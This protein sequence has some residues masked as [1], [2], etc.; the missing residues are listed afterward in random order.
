MI[1]SSRCILSDQGV[2]RRAASSGQSRRAVPRSLPRRTNNSVGRKKAKAKDNSARML[3]GPNR[4]VYRRARP[5]F[6]M[7]LSR[8]TP[9]TE[10]KRTTATA[11]A[12]PLSAESERLA[13]S[14]VKTLEFESALV[15]LSRETEITSSPRSRKKTATAAPALFPSLSFSLPLFLES[16]VS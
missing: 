7:K 11:N 4:S 2:D 16:E 10:R 5:E 9:E 14:L 6:W 15:P 1:S 8:Q 3:G 12:N 13:N